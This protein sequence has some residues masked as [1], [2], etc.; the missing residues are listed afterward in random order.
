M[1]PQQIKEEKS[2]TCSTSLPVDSSGIQDFSKDVP[3]QTTTNVV[4]FTPVLVTSKKRDENS[5]GEK[6]SESKKKEGSL[7]ENQIGSFKNYHNY[8]ASSFLFFQS[9]K[10][11][12]KKVERL[13][14]CHNA[15]ES[16]LQS[17]HLL[18]SICSSMEVKKSETS[19]SEEESLTVVSSFAPQ[20][21]SLLSMRKS[22]EYFRDLRLYGAPEPK[23][24]SAVPHLPSNNSN[25]SVNK[26]SEKEGGGMS[27]EEEST[28][29]EDK[30]GYQV[31]PHE[32]AE[33]E[34][35]RK[36]ESSSMEKDANKYKQVTDW[37]KHF[38]EVLEMPIGEQKSLMLAS[39]IKDFHF[40]ARKYG[41]VIISEK[42]LPLEKK[43]I[44]PVSLG[45]LAGGD[46]SRIPLLF[47]QKS[48]LY[49]TSPKKQ[50][51]ICC[52]WLISFFSFISIPALFFWREKFV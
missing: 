26:C 31:E 49:L 40:N 35:E 38:Q 16:L 45:G 28:L 10:D 19:S 47:P 37:N 18:A 52:S 2:F 43:T 6:V 34:E 46:V 48:F 9:D 36:E 23:M 20:M 39:L 30:F 3:I 42:H 32:S 4:P 27:Q 1:Q 25:A 15:F 7:E 17:P 14:N 29:E 11:S 8:Q 13:E 41:E 22:E 33:G 12:T 51:E 44:K 50:T 5:F 21:P 24:Y